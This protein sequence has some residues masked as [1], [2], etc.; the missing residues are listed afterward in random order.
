MPRLILDFFIASLLLLGGIFLVIYRENAVFDVREV[1]TVPS[2]EFSD[3]SP[4][5][6]IVFSEVLEVED[7]EAEDAIDTSEPISQAEKINTVEEPI[8][9]SPSK[10]IASTAI[11][12]SSIESATSVLRNALVNIVCYAPQGSNI[13]SISGSGVFIDPKGIILTNAHIAQYFLLSERGVSCGVRTGAPAIDAYRASLL[14]ISSEWIEENAELIVKPAPSGTGEHDFA[15]LAVTKSI[16]QFRPL[17]EQFPF[18]SLA[19]DPVDRDTPVVIGG[20]GAQFLGAEQIQF[21]LFPTLVFGVVKDIFTF[22]SN[23]VDVLALGGSAAA[24]Q[25]SSGGG[26]ADASG[27][28]VG[29]I[30]TSTQE[31]ITSE[32]SLDAITA[33]YIRGAYATESGEALDLLIERSLAE[34]IANFES[35]KKELETTLAG[36]LN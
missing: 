7:E 22:S 27:K 33:S 11:T 16:S 3:T 12:T 30:V 6:P 19:N 26:V 20:Y 31:K 5:Y 23:T 25:G 34:S 10:Q 15:L 29:T 35:K 2:I 24:Q 21:M 36:F 14:F 18:I 32:R 1:G 13:R 9:E 28:L 8:P 4:F 17:P